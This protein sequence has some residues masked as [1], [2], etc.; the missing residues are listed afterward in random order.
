VVKGL[1]YEKTKKKERKNMMKKKLIGFLK[2]KFQKNNIY[3]Y[4]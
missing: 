3:I 4:Q 2:L 1:R